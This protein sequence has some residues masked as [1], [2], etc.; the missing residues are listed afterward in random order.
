M[1]NDEIENELRASFASQGLLRTLGAQLQEV[2]VGR[3]VIEVPFSPAVTQQNGYF[4]GGV[5]GALA[6]TAGGY[7]ALTVLP[8]GV[9]ILTLE[10]KINFLRPALGDRIV[11]EAHVLKAG[12]SVTVTRVDVYAERNGERHLCAAA[13]QSIMKIISRP[14]E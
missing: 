14:R 10:Y 6:D 5:V 3:C 11:A 9:D 12:R 8:A 1:L 2:S 13:Q 4:H 7:A